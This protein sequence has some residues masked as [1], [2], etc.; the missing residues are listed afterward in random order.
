MSEAS[1]LPDG[2]RLT[3]ALA[4]LSAAVA[5]LASVASQTCWQETDQALL[6]GLVELG[7]RRQAPG[8]HRAGP[9]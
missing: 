5:E 7:R 9:A 2:S 6:A 1:D 3:A 4:G 8:H